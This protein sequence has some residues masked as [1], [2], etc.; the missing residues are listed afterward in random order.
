MFLSLRERKQALRACFNQK[1]TDYSYFSVKTGGAPTVSLRE[2]IMLCRM[3]RRK[4][5]QLY[6]MVLKKHLNSR[7][8]RDF[9]PGKSYIFIE[10]A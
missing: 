9:T 1:R 4:K 2:L 8:I 6:C 7:K 5:E 10:N 3:R